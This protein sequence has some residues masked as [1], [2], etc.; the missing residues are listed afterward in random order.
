MIILRN[1]DVGQ[2]RNCRLWL[3]IGT[4]AYVFGNPQPRNGFFYYGT[5][6]EIGTPSCAFR[7]RLGKWAR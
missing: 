6:I 4:T 1:T 5:R 7:V 3:Q 2:A